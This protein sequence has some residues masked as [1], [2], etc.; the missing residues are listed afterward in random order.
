VNENNVAAFSL[1]NGDAM[2]PT[3]SRPKIARIWRG[4]TTR[5][6]ADAYEAYNYEAGITCPLVTQITEAA[7]RPA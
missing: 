3:A 7:V 5:A 2:P 6:R 4:R 1:T